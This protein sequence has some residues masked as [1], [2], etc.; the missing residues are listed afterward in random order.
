MQT[1]V[2]RALIL[3]ITHKWAPPSPG[4]IA[5]RQYC[6]STAHCTGVHCAV[7]TA[8]PQWQRRPLSRR[9]GKYYFMELLYSIFIYFPPASGLNMV[10]VEYECNHWLQS[11]HWS[12][13]QGLSLQRL[14]NCFRALRN[15]SGCS[16]F[17]SKGRLFQD[18]AIKYFG[19][20]ESGVR[21]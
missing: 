7:L 3:R 21:Q 12:M 16:D 20:S 4:P 11:Q 6:R 1:E 2:S 5:P 13:L 9:R 8:A 17:M 18:L 19:L 15:L 10:N 14:K